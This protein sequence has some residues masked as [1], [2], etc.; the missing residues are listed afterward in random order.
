[1]FLSLHLRF[2]IHTFLWVLWLFFRRV[3][4]VYH[5]P[6]GSPCKQ[7]KDKKLLL[8][9]KYIKNTIIFIKNF[10]HKYSQVPRRFYHPRR[11]F[12]GPTPLSF[13]TS[14]SEAPDIL[15]S[16]PSNGSRPRQSL[17]SDL[18]LVGG[19]FYDHPRLIDYSSWTCSDSSHETTTPRRIPRRPSLSFTLTRWNLSNGTGIG[20]GTR[21]TNP[22]RRTLRSI[23]PGP[24]VPTSWTTQW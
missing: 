19:L 10:I 4:S 23:G 15:V 5:N 13:P 24:V 11:L 14:R 20:G 17:P 9:H 8:L 6:P 1:M 7:N 3:P 22:T 2:K 16:R 21:L 12:S 18:L